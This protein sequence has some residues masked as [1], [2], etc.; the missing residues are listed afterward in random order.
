MSPR[1]SGLVRSDARDSERVKPS[2]TLAETFTADCARLSLRKHD[3]HY[4]VRVEGELL[5][6]TT[7]TQSEAQ[8]AELACERF[9][10]KSVLVGGLGFGFTLRRVLELVG[11]DASVEVAELIPEMVAWNREHLRGVNGELLDDPRV[12]VTIAD[13]YAVLRRAVPGQYDAVLLDVDNGPEALVDRRNGRIYSDRGLKILSRA[14]C[15]GGRA[16]FWSASIDHSFMDRLLTAGFHAHAIAAKAYP[17]A[18]RPTHTLFVA[19][20]ME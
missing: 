19:D 8:M 9:A 11:E 7:A 1:C 10:P 17:Q 6:S 2:T 13:V 14:L 3:G 15:A 4:H 18:V 16:V 5:M 20:W 12:K